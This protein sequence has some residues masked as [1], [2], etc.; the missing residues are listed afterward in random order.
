[1]A[2]K[3]VAK[4]A[5]SKKATPKRSDRIAAHPA[6]TENRPLQ[7][8]DIDEH[9]QKLAEKEWASMGNA[10]RRI[11]AAMKSANTSLANAEAVLSDPK[12]SDAKRKRAA[13]SKKQALTRKKNVSTL[14]K[15]G[16]LENVPTTIE[17]AADRRINFFDEGIKRNRSEGDI[18]TGEGTSDTPISTGWYFKHADDLNQ[19]ADMHGI[20]RERIY[21]ASGAMSPQNSPDNEKS[22]IEALASAHYSNHAVKATTQHGA[23]L[24]GVPV[25]ES[26]NFR[27]IPSDIVQKVLGKEEMRKH[28]DTKVN[29][30]GIAKGGTNVDRGVGILRGEIDTDNFLAGGPNSGPKVSS[31]V[32]NI[33]KAG[34]ASLAERSEYFRRAHEASP[35][36]KPYFEQD[37]L[38]GKDWEADPWG[39]ANTST[40]ILNPRGHTAEDTWMKS[41]SA[42]QPNEFEAIPTGGKESARVGKFVGSDRDFQKISA[43]NIHPTEA[44][45]PNPNSETIIHALN[46]ASTIR[47]AEKITQRASDAGRNVGTGVPST[48]VQET[49]WSE[50]RIQAGKDDAYEAASN[51]RSRSGEFHGTTYKYR[52]P[53]NKLVEKPHPTLFD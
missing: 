35:G 40:G 16:L 7:M 43:S 48:L 18:R 20:D 11:P 21:T 8:S 22:A 44:G 1:M 17:S 39:H 12:A 38:F 28:F 31:Y 41:I 14:K 29:I 19:I 9:G 51:A 24:L 10:K 53:S 23:R 47:A 30:E 32:D 42:A 49:S 2:E 4:K 3:R 33:R 52:T 50:Y 46:N 13:S 26:K 27:D 25:G 34:N 37:T 45:H 6:V 5:T 15:E 36:S